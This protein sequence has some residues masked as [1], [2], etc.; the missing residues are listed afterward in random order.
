MNTLSVWAQ[1]IIGVLGAGYIANIVA[2]VSLVINIRQKNQELKDAKLQRLNDNLLQ[3]TRP[4]IDPL[5]IPINKILAKLESRYDEYKI[6]KGRC[7]G[8]KVK[9]SAD[10]SSDA[11]ESQE[12]VELGLLLDGNKYD[13]ILTLT[14]VSR[15]MIDY[16]EKM[17]VEGTSAFLTSEFEKRLDSFIRFLRGV[18]IISHTYLLSFKAVPEEQP[19]VYTL[20][21]PEF[22]KEFYSEID[23][24]RSYIR[25]L[26]LGTTDTIKDTPRKVLD[27]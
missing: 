13:A 6:A 16:Q 8:Y 19:K 7:H 15:E 18:M 11:L 10:L 17:I 21:T 26:A 9:K 14:T 22:E 12:S 1:I 3:N 24:I 23:Y 25:E 20:G 5:Y 2:I 4:H 27:K